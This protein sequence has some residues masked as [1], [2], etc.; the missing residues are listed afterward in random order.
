MIIEARAHTIFRLTNQEIRAMNNEI[1]KKV[2]KRIGEGADFLAD[3]VRDSIIETQSIAY[4][5]PSKKGDGTDHPVSK[6]GFPPNEDTGRLREGVWSG[7]HIGNY[8]GAPEVLAMLGVT[9]ISDED[10]K[11]YAKRLELGIGVL[12]RPFFYDTILKNIKSKEIKKIFN[13]IRHLVNN[14]LTKRSSLHYP[15]AG[16]KVS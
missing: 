5:V 1:K 7:S 16:K 14:I 3:K 15:G 12:R 13:Q 8:Q 6:P 9:A 10:R 11:D 2:E 4:I